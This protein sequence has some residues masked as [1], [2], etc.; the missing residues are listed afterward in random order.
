MTAR[1]SK[2]LKDDPRDFFT[3][4]ASVTEKKRFTCDFGKAPER[5]FLLTRQDEYVS[6]TENLPVSTL[7]PQSIQSRQRVW[8]NSTSQCNFKK[9]ISRDSEM[10]K[11]PLL[12]N[13]KL[14]YSKEKREE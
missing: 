4:L 10:Y 13:F 8:Q 1:E 2:P 9:Q 5:N 7:N 6:S 14:D 12:E 3:G 11:N